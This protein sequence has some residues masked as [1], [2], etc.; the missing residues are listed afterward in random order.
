MVLKTALEKEG[1]AKVEVPELVPSTAEEV[2]EYGLAERRRRRVWLLIPTYILYIRY[3][4][5]RMAHHIF[6]KDI[7]I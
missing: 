7:Y 1:K 3:V 6:D 2:L 4:Y 5:H